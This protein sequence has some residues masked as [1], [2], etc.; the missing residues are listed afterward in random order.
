MYL[1]VNPDP[2]CLVRRRKLLGPGDHYGLALPNGTVVDLNQGGV[3]VASPEAF[4]A[5]RDVHTVRV[6]DRSKYAI[7]RE[8]LHQALVAP[9]TYQLVG[10]NCE[11]FANWLSGEDA[12][13]G[14]VIAAGIAA[15]V[16][17]VIAAA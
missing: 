11:D 2:M 13:S 17:A 14:Q 15:A 3:R 16:I 1:K 8:R 5:G 9:P 4:A 10:M 7:V 12:I 6:V